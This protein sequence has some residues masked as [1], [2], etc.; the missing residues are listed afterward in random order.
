VLSHALDAVTELR[1]SG[2]DVGLINK[3]T[4]NQ[5]DEVSLASVGKSGF[6]L[7]AESQN[8]LN[9]LGSRYGTWLLERGFSPR[10]ARLGTHLRGQGGGDEQVSQQG[11]DATSILKAIKKLSG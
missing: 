10:Y 11:L 3:S 5:V 7:V 1:E 4:L 2:L 9:G 8:V 6:V